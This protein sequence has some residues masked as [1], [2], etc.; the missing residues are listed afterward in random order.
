MKFLTV[1]HVLQ[2]WML[3][4]ESSTVPLFKGVLR[5][6]CKFDLFLVSESDKALTFSLK[7][8]LWLVWLLSVSPSGYLPLN[9]DDS[10]VPKQQRPALLNVKT[11]LFEQAWAWICACR[12]ERTVQNVQEGRANLRWSYGKPLSMSRLKC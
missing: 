11:C 7:F 5:N 1:L 10:Q 6:H 2:G 4:A 3:W 8:S 9:T 12:P